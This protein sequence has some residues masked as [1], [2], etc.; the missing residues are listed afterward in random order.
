[1]MSLLKM[2]DDPLMKFLLGYYSEGQD[3]T[4]KHN[5]NLIA[6]TGVFLPSKLCVCNEKI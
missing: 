1:M 2:D 6:N 5:F 3:G 4:F